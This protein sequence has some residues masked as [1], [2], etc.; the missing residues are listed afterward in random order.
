MLENVAPST[1]V[2]A[3]ESDE[4]TSKNRTVAVIC[5]DD[6]LRDQVMCTLV[7]LLCV[8]ARQFNFYPTPEQIP[9]IAA[10]GCDVFLVEVDSNVDHALEVIENLSRGTKATVMATSDGSASDLVIRSMR[11]GA[12]EFLVLPL[13]DGQME[14][15]LERLEQRRAELIAPTALGRLCVFVGAKG[16]AGTTT[17]ATN[18]A[19]A[20]ALESGKSVL[21]VDFDLPLGDAILNFGLTH[22]F[23]TLD[24]LQNHQRLD[25]MLLSR[26]LARH[27]SGLSILAAPGKLG[28]VALTKVAIDK[29]I[30]IAREEFA[31]VVVDAGSRFDLSDTALFHAEAQLYLVMQVSIADLRNSNR[32][33]SEFIAPKLPRMEVIL[34]RHSASHVEIDESQITKALLRPAKWRVPNDYVAVHDMQTA[35]RPLALG[36]SSIARTIRQ[37]AR[38]GLELPPAPKRKR[39][40]FLGCF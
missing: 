30:Q 27:D 14:A 16:G 3:L 33:A 5:P 36:D 31:C 4:F 2:P 19:L 15:A 10:L 7:R 25:G 11:A 12:R 39:K 22:Q 17:I 13:T 21:L 18:F 34:N 26:F 8:S 9:Q 1:E 38:E 37:M 20:A 32:V 24:A 6:K 29:L 28:P 23:S 40:K 35:A